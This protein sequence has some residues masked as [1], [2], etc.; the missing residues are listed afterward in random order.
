MI[1][2][3]FQ[4]AWLEQHGDQF[5]CVC[6]RVCVC[7]CLYRL[8]V[9]PVTLTSAFGLSAQYTPP[10]Y[11]LQGMR[12]ASSR[13]ALMSC[14]QLSSTSQQLTL[15]QRAQPLSLSLPQPPSMSLSLSLS[16]SAMSPVTDPSLPAARC[17]SQCFVTFQQF[18]F[19]HVS[20]ENC[21]YGHTHKSRALIVTRQS[22][23]GGD[24]EGVGVREGECVTGACLPAIQPP[25]D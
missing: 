15:T 3:E 11:C 21:F 17:L 22:A 2:D 10:G 8:L 1:A 18:R 12:T 5:H 4:L 16:A 20:V 24:G 14:R 23:G 9:Y 13:G 19:S 6:A 25:A 7:V